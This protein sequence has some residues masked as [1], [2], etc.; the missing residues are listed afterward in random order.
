[1]KTE[2]KLLAVAIALVIPAGLFVKFGIGGPLR[3]WAFRYGAAILYEVFWVLVVR[4][5]FPRVRPAFAAAGV[6][7][8]TCILETLQLWK[9]P[10]LEAV[11]HTLVGG[12]L[13]GTTFDAADF[14]YYGLGSLLGCLILRAIVSR[15]SSSRDVSSGDGEPS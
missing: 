8:A 9:P 11:R 15:S 10:W 2:R 5:V 6:F 12:V 14:L 13:L 4:F 1:M 3:E 7:V